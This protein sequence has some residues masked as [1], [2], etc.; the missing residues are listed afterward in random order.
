MDTV[1]N[2]HKELEICLAEINAAGLG[3]LEP[4]HIEKLDAIGTRADVLGLHEGK[5]LVVNYSAALK[6]FNDGKST[7]DSVRLRQTALEFYLKN[8]DGIAT[9]EL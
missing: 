1:E 6:S 5:K 8:T 3:K 4:Q 7:E 2:L 9:E